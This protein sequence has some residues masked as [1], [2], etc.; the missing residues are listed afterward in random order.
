MRKIYRFKLNNFDKDEVTH[1]PD[2]EDGM[3][4]RSFAIID[5]KFFLTGRGEMK[6]F[7]LEKEEWESGPKPPMRA[8][9][10]ATA[11]SSESLF[12]CGGRDQ[13]DMAQD[14]AFRFD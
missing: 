3:F 8:Q 10:S 5:R 11:A 14:V 7:S 9:F 2:S 1:Y 4:C 12:V 13:N 6:I